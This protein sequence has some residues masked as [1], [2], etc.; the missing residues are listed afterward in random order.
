M[1]P[2]ASIVADSSSLSFHFN[3]ATGSYELIIKDPAWSFAGQLDAPVQQSSLR[4]GSDRLGVYQ[5]LSLSWRDPR[6]PVTAGVRVYR[7]HPIA[8]FSQQFDTASAIPPAPFPSFTSLPGKLHIF[9][10]RFDDFA[11]PQFAANENASPWMLFDDQANTL[12][13]SP[14]SHFMVASM[15]G[16]AKYSMASGFN[17]HLRDLP[18]GF[19]QETVMAFGKG[20]NATHALWG[21]TLLSLEGASRPGNDADASL[22]YLGY[23]TDNG[24]S[25]YYNYDFKKGYAGTLKALVERYRS[26][27]I[28]IRYLQLDSWWY[29]KSLTGPDGEL[30]HSKNASLPEGEWNR[31]GGLLDYKAHKFLFPEGLEAFQKS[32]ALP[33]LTHNRWVDLASPYRQ[34]YKMSGLA[35]VDPKWWDEIATYLKSSGVATYEQDW[36]D[37]IYQYSPSFSSDPDTANAFMDNMARACSEQGITMQY[38]MPYA[39]HF[40]QGSLYPN[41]TTIRTSGDRFNPGLWNDFLYTSRLASSL[42]IWPWAD[43]FNSG[44][45]NNL[46]LATLSA[47]PVG[48]GDELGTENKINLLKAVRADGVIVKPDL[49]IVPMDRT[50]ISDANGIVAPFLASTSTLHGDIQTAYVFAFNRSGTPATKLRFNASEL[51]IRGPVYVYDYFSGLGHRLDADHSFAQALDKDAAA[52]Y[53]LAPIGKSGIAFLGDKGKFVG[54]GKQRVASLE[55]SSDRLTVKL[56]F[57]EAEKGCILH[58]YARKAPELSSESGSVTLLHFDAATKYFEVAANP[59][60]NNKA[61]QLKGD[62]IREMT[63]TLN[64]SHN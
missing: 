59:D 44:E 51:G 15:L 28:P 19:R 6:T 60:P 33:L 50:Y 21:K 30:G 56:L 46:L 14:A 5:E 58:G 45:I 27:E 48:I 24:A 11:A 52:F 36:L 53:V 40:L 41:L 39:C 47:G 64:G 62:S 9:S 61:I 2:A 10:H 54:T 7:A 22:K 32:I 35:A 42:G 17:P 13:I 31:Y 12:L 43:V 38:C 63:L 1:A 55:E 16:D 18:A 57:S 49:P 29:Y 3:D 4:Q 34:K 26:E 8:V 25:Y 37:R 20:I 23:W